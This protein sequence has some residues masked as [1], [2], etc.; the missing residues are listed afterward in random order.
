LVRVDRD[1]ALDDEPDNV[2]APP[3]SFVRAPVSAG[4]DGDDET[5][6]PDEDSEESGAADATP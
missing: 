4:P 3:A 1:G 2:G 6:D 5:D